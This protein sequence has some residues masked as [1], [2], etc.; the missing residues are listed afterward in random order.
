MLFFIKAPLILVS[1]TEHKDKRDINILYS[2]TT[3]PSR[4]T[5]LC[6]L[7]QQPFE[8][9]RVLLSLACIKQRDDLRSGRMLGRL[10]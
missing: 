6:H 9:R 2:S 1:N 7:H 4:T 5:I 3:L 8:S 10:F